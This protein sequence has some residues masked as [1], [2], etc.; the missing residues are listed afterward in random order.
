MKILGCNPNLGSNQSMSLSQIKFIPPHFHLL[1]DISKE[2]HIFFGGENNR[3]RCW[4]AAVL[5][6]VFTKSV[7]IKETALVLAQEQVC[8][9]GQSGTAFLK[10][11]DPHFYTHTCTPSNITRPMTLCAISL[12][13]AWVH[14]Q[15]RSSKFGPRID[16]GINQQD[17]KMSDIIIWLQVQLEGFV[18]DSRRSY[19]HLFLFTSFTLLLF[20][21]RRKYCQ[22]RAEKGLLSCCIKSCLSGQCPASFH[23]T[24]DCRLVTCGKRWH[25]VEPVLGGWAGL[26]ES[27]RKESL[28]PGHAIIYNSKILPFSQIFA[29]SSKV[30]LANTFI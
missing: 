9:K 7:W 6:S 12:Y 15:I 20:F 25:R 1:Q 24:P 21:M 19:Y 30:E 11:L 4:P 22:H 3:I 8:T 28:G 10:F 13:I 29:S 23:L 18:R 17:V 16:R 5:T 27:F 2:I 14:S 26:E